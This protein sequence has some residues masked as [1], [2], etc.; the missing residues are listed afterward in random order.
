MKFI[1]NTAI[2]VFLTL[3]PMLTQ[4]Q[5]NGPNT[6][7]QHVII[8]IQENRTPD[9]LFGSDAFAAHP[10]LPGA[11]LARGGECESIPPQPPY[12]VPLESINLGNVCDPHHGHEFSWVKSYDG[13]AMDGACIISSKGCSMPFPEYTYVQSSDVVPYFQIASQYG[14]ANYMFQTNQGPS[15]PAHQ[16]LFSGTSAP[17][18]IGDPNDDCA[19]KGPCYHEWFAA[20]N[21]GQNAA[22]WVPWHDHGDKGGPAGEYAER[23]SRVR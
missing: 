19:N 6:K 14:Y 4:A 22:L 11:D 8:V 3:E 9:N 18:Q 13:G 20:E 5:I 15:F 17:D 12:T 16:F 1:R 2:L 7:F 23:V 21:A 10:Q